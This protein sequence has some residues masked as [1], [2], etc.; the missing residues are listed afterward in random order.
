MK[1]SNISFTRLLTPLEKIESRV[2]AKEAKK[3]IGL[4]NMAIVTHSVSFPSLPD[5]DMGVGLLSLNGG[6]RNYINFLYDNGFDAIS[7]EPMGIIRPPLY[8]PYE[9]SLLS[10]K[11]LVDLKELTEDKW[12]NILS[13]SDFKEVVENK[14][15]EV[16]LNSKN[17]AQ[18]VTFDKN[19]VI[20]DYV[21]QAQK[22]PLRKAFENFKMKVSAGNSVALKLSAEFEEFKKQNDYF[23]AND[24]IYSVLFEKN[25][26]QPFET[27]Q[28]PL[29]R[30]LFDDENLDFD[31]NQRNEEIKRL[32]E[33]YSS[34]LEFYKFCQ[35]VVNKQ[36]QDFTMYASKLSQIRYEQDLKT[37]LEA[38]Q[39]GIISQ[40]KF[41][42]LK[43]KLD[44]YK[45]ACD[46][47]NVIGD[48]QVGY[49]DM[50]IYSNPSFFTKDEFMGAP[51]NFLKA[52]LGQDWDFKFIPYE[53]LFNKDGSLASGGEFLKKTFKKAFKDNPGG[54]R[55]DHI[56]GLID[57]WSYQK[58]HKKSPLNDV[59]NRY[60]AS[61]SR[62]VFKYLLG[63]QLSQLDKY[64]LN[65]DTIV[66]VIDP[67][68][69]IFDE[70]SLDRKFLMQN[71]VRDFDKIQEIFLSKKDEVEKVYSNVIEKIILSA[72]K[73]V[74]LERCNKNNAEL[75]SDEIERNAKKL[76]ICE[77][78]GALTLPVKAIMKK[79]GLIGLRDASRAI[80]DNETHYFRE[81]NPNE[82]GNYWLISTHDTLPYKKL[83][84]S[85][86]F[87]KQQAHID[88][89]ASELGIARPQGILDYIKAKVIRIFAA[90][91]KTSTS[92]KVMLNWLDLFAIEK[93][94]N[95]PGLYD[96]TKNWN[97]RICDNSDS[98]DRIYWEDLL[99]QN[100]GINIL[101][102]LVKTM[103]ICGVACENKDLQEELER[104]NTIAQA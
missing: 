91:K 22:E 10:K 69:G 97:L 15:Y 63:N 33:E 25:N 55:I 30:V 84:E 87:K 93:P 27:W 96:K 85:Y 3:A 82:Q 81:G 80:P 104:L 2:A 45:V 52:S 19:Q 53:K 94:Y 83:F 24:A 71:G 62:H 12:A 99:P 98:P 57:P 46:G 103:D 39:K 8:S 49:S 60:V 59:S 47:I 32:E 101:D 21:F 76:I 90:D 34:E 5:E 100:K 74:V 26:C 56:I 75:S 54:L 77:D 78:L 89:V 35:F 1:V 66:G 92:N 31:F 58:I 51:P 61:G 16:W 29:H 70:N 17:K 18:K 73:E 11:N 7:I 43:A 86:D 9:G 4:D 50:D 6:A 48:K 23:L 14:N 36:Q 42:Y 40:A 88:Y 68:K 67:I 102:T 65:S 95:T 44:E 38:R 13:V 28:N 37:I 64:N 20:Y 41:D 79:Y 72:A